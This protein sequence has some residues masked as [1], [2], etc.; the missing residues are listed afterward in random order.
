MEIDD[1]INFFFKK[2]IPF[3]LTPVHESESN[4]LKV[5]KGLKEININKFENEWQRLSKKYHF[6][7]NNYYKYVPTFLSTP[8]KLL[9]SYT[10]FA[11]AVMFFINPYGEVFPCEFK[12]ISI[13]NVKKESLFLIWK[14]ARRLRSQIASSKRDCVCWSHCVVPLNNRLSRY[15]SF[16]KVF[17]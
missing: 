10:C 14:K 4:Y 16:K 2:N 13:G 3:Q 12:R 15:I 6:L 7:N 5:E 8:N 9:H 11:G 1:Y 17:K